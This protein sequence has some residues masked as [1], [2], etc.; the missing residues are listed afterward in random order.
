MKQEMPGD[1]ECEL[2]INVALP[3]LPD[4]S[5]SPRLPDVGLSRK[6]AVLAGVLE[7][8]A[9]FGVSHDA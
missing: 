4:V 9:A 7:L 5:V 2:R 6:L 1:S 3:W 8:L